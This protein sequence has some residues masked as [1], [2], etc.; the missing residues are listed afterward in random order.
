ME[1]AIGGE[2]VAPEDPVGAVERSEPPAGLG[3]DRRQGRHVVEREFW[4]GGDVDGP[5]GQQHVGP[6]VAIRT[7]PPAVAGEIQHGIGAPESIPTR[8]AGERD[9]RVRQSLDTGRADPCCRREAPP[10]IRSA[11]L[12]GPPAAPESRCRNQAH[13]RLL[14]YDERDQG[15]PH[16]DPADEVVR[17]VDGVH[18]PTPRPVTRRLELLAHHGV[19][20]S[21]PG[22]L[23]SDEF[24][25]GPIGVAHEGQVRL[26]LD[27]EILRPEAGHGH[28][29]H[30]VRE[31]MGQAQVI[32]V[33]RHGRTR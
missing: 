27:R 1:V 14:G 6:E 30:R 3:H 16:R 18:D 10:G 17:P 22:E 9:A 25:C 13:D 32:V 28:P 23:G 29:L 21:S 15:G 4:F 7:L 2:C 33:G 31:H 26:G 11:A 19:A 12:G 5:L 8:D 20:R 24:L